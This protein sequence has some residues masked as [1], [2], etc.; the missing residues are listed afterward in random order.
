MADEY[1]DLFGDV[2]DVDE[3]DQKIEVRKVCGQRDAHE[4]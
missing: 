4:L 1:E 2:N 3:C